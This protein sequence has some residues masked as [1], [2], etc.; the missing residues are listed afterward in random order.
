MTP[1]Q[2]G[3]AMHIERRSGDRR[4]GNRRCA[5]RRRMPR[6]EPWPSGADIVGYALWA[7]DGAMGRVTDLCVEQESLAVTEI[8]AVARRLFW[9]ERI[10][11]PLGAVRRVDPLERRVEVKLSRAEI[12]RFS[13]SRAF[14]Q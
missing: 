6:G 1:R 10:F 12:R 3:I 7:L 9:S 14:S 8:I 2:A 5:D 13:R 4:A 11:V